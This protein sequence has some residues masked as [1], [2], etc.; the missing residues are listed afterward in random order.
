MATVVVPFRST[1]PKRRLAAVVEADRVR[2]AHAM[3][4]D[5]L[6]AA[7]PLGDILVVSAKAPKLP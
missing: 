3:L 6:A 4:E 7:E 2:L 1:D 5:V